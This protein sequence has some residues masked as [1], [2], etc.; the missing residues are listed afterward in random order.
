VE[1]DPITPAI[2]HHLY[3]SIRIHGGIPFQQFA[4]ADESLDVA[5]QALEHCGVTGPSNVSPSD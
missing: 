3:P 5:R 1:L 2:A 4:T